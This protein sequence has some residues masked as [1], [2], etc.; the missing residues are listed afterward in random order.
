MV[1]N[2]AAHPSPSPPGGEGRGEGAAEP[3]KSFSLMDASP[4]KLVATLKNDNMFWR[5]HAQRLLVERGKQDVV[6]ALIELSGD[7]ATDSI[8]LSPGAI[9]ALWTLHGL[10][11]LD[12][13]EGKA[14]AAAVAAL[15]HKS[16]GVRRN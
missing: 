11:V 9:H 10:G 4:E 12:G 13:S 5:L 7:P 6:P 15:K 2:A 3:P 8:G 14:T 16:A 1:Y